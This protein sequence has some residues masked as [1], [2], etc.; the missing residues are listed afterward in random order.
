MRV[1][2]NQVSTCSS[3]I[4][5]EEKNKVTAGRNIKRGRA[6]ERKLR[7]KARGKWYNGAR[8]LCCHRLNSGFIIKNKQF[9]T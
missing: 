8:N 3:L 6:R 4:S 7:A 9:A 2:L 5:Q 1:K